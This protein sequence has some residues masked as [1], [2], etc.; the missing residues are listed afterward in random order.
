MKEKYKKPMKDFLN[1]YMAYN[2]HL[3]YQNQDELRNIFLNSIMTVLESI[4]KMAFKPNISLNAAVFDS[5]MVGVAKRIASGSIENIAKF[6]VFYKN[7]MS[8]ENYRMSWETATTDVENV[9][10]R[11]EMAIKAFNNIE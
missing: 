10:Q 3:K 11:I 7:L 8:C 6:Q 9:N 5:I 2:R 1:K 4:G